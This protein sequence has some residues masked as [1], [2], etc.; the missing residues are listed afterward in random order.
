M[1]GGGGV[2]DVVLVDIDVPQLPTD[3]DSPSMNGYTMSLPHGS[4]ISIS[5]I[6][7]LQLASFVR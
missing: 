3:R 6:L 2:Y 4:I 7:C 1:K 5:W